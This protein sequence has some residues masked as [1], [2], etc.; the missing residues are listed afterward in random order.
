MVILWVPIQEGCRK[1]LNGV[2]SNFGLGCGSKDNLSSSRILF[3]YDVIHLAGVF[4]LD[5][6]GND[7]FSS[8]S[9]MS[10]A[11]IPE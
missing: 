7:D 2:T 8:A 1:L 9:N 5:L 4:G 3:H 6:H 10:Q 11:R